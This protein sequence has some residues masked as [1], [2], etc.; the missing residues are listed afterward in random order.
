MVLGGYLRIVSAPSVHHVAPYRYLLPNVYLFMA[1]IAKPNV[2][3]CS[4][5]P[6]FVSTSPAFMRSSTRHPAGPHG[7]LAQKTVNRK[8]STQ[9]PQQFM[10]A[11]SAPP[12]V[13]S[14]VR[15]LYT[16]NIYYVNFY[17]YVTKLHNIVSL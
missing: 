12:L 1:D 6:G 17:V 5:R 11:V 4:C 13:G 16:Y 14:V 8:I 7:R 15:S 10:T 2:F 9:F 3:V